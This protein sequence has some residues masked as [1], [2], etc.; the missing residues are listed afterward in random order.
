MREPVRLIMQR[1]IWNIDSADCQQTG[2][3]L[4]FDSRT[5]R[6][7]PRNFRRRLATGCFNFE[8]RMLK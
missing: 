5:Y 6:C 7:S 4:A 1:I 2:G 8:S 3:S